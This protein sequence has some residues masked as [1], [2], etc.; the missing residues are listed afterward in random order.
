MRRSKNNVIKKLSN[1][2]TKLWLFTHFIISVF[3]FQYRFT[4]LRDTGLGEHSTLPIGYDQTIENDDGEMTY[5]YPDL[6]KTEINK[7]EIFIKN[8]ILRNGNLCAEISDSNKTDSVFIVY[9]LKS[10]TLKTFQ[11]E[12]DYTIY[13]QENKLPDTN[14]FYDFGKHY[15]GYVESFPKWKKWL[16]P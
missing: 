12:K 9:D 15:Y 7:D 11:N 2:K 1:Q 3:L 5:F 16:L 13:A 10:K 14:E 8:F 6:N 4:Y